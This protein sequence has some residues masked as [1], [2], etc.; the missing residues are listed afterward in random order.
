MNNLFL[1]SSCQLSDEHP[2][3]YKLLVLYHILSN[4]PIVP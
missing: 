3:I 4:K 2:A 1:F